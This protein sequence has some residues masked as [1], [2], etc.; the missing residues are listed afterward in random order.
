LAAGKTMLLSAQATNS[1]GTVLTSQTFV[2]ST[3]NSAIATVEQNGTVTAVAPGTVDVAAAIGA[4]NNRVT[5]TITPAPVAASIAVNAGNGQSATV[6]T[7]VPQPPSVIVKDAAGDPV[8]G[9]TVTFAVSQG[10]GSVTGAT[11]L[12]NSAGIATVGSWT[13]GPTAGTQTLTATSGTLAGSPVTFTATA[14]A[15]AADLRQYN[16]NA[17]SACD[18]PD[19]RTGRVE[20]ETAHL[21]IVADLSNPSGGFTTAD[22]QSFAATFESLVW[23]VVTGNFGAPADI[24]GGGRVIAFFTRAVNELTPANSTGVVGGFFFARDLFPKVQTGNFPACPGSNQAEMFY[25][26]VPDPT[27]VVNG[28]V[29]A[30]DVVRR[31]AVGVIGHEMQHLINSSRRLFINTSAQ[32]PETIFMEEGLAHIAEEL[33]FYEASGLN[34]KSNLTAP[35][36]QSTPQIQ[37]AANSYSTS[38]WGRLSTYLR[39]PSANSPYASNDGLATRGAT[40]SWL[41]YLADRGTATPASEPVCVPPMV[42]GVNA[43]CTIEGAA[44][45]SF[46]ID[47]GAGT[48]YTLVAFADGAG[49][50]ATGAATN[51]LTVSGPPTPSLFAAGANRLQIG[52]TTI[53][54]LTAGVPFD[55]A[56]HRRLRAMERSD[57]PAM[58]PQA[59]ARFGKGARGPARLSISRAPGRPS[60]SHA[61]VEAV[62]GRLVNSNTTGLVNVRAEFGQDIGGATRDWA[63]ANYVDDALTGM[64]AQYTHPSWNFRSVLQLL[65]SNEF[66]YPLQT[67]NL[68]TSPA[69]TMVNGGAA[70]FRLGVAA[71]TTSTVT[72][73]VNGGA[74]PPNF[75]LV[76][77]RTK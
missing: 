42:L 39:A 74:P 3:S 23:P 71:S 70:Y 43:R 72:F 25:I 17:N 40:W 26:L 56:F 9:V 30:T 21:T 11:P 48:E 52:A 16:A 12:T 14:V 75:R 44:A 73:V 54:S 67:Q 31:I 13:M 57:L 76:V 55:V 68:A 66:A 36:I 5:L 22:Y 45:A 61:P 2:W 77:V 32:W 37:A 46:V 38:N 64:P 15:L 60:F 51:A 62:W 69:V 18:S 58:V 10:G 8:A 28:N 53:E 20:A 24:D 65:P 63:V 27:G 4:K 50:T 1:A 29:R 7:A 47:G 6:N 49:L 33:L 34:P 35:T 59:R 19:I 41:R